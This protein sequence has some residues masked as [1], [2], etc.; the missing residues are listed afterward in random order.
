MRGENESFLFEEIENWMKKLK[1]AT[2]W[3]FIYE[4]LL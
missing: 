4:I 3:F 2:I 1:N